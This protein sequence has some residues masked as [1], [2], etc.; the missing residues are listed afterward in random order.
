MISNLRVNLCLN[1]EEW[2]EYHRIRKEQIFDPINVEY[3]PDHPSITKA[4]HYH[5]VLYKGVKI[6]ATTHIEFL[7]ENETALRSLAVD[8]LQQ[9]KGFG[10]YMIQFLEKWLR[11][12]NI[13]VLKMHVR[14][15]AETFY[16]KL[17][18]VDIEFNDISIQ[19]N[20]V[21]LGKML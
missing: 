10:K 9:N 16:R 12:Q 4:N 14:P 15:S 18:F 6:V 13:K 2:Q 11:S 1:E 5:F 7:N 8:Y 21:D 20:Y 17:G 19:K 3:N